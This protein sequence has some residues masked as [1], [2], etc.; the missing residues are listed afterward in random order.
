MK[1]NSELR[2]GIE[3]NL[4]RYTLII[5]CIVVVV[6]SVIGDSII[7]A[8]LATRDRQAFRSNKV[9]SVVIRHLAAVDIFSAI[10]NTLPRI[11]ALV[12]DTWVVGEFLGHFEIHTSRI[13]YTITALL[14]CEMAIVK[15]VC[16]RHPLRAFYWSKRFGRRICALLWV[17]SLIINAPLMIGSLIMIGDT[18]YFEYLMYSCYYNFDSPKSPNWLKMYY[19]ICHGILTIFPIL[20]LFITSGLILAVA[21]RTASRY[22][23]TIRREGVLTVLLT[24]AAFLI[25]LLP[26]F[27]VSVL[28]SAGIMNKTIYRATNFLVYLNTMANFFIYLLSVS[29]FRHYLK[30]KVLHLLAFVKR[31]MMNDRVERPSARIRN[32]VSTFTIS[33]GANAEEQM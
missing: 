7:L 18:Q 24:V 27:I 26:F 32:P 28:E 23:Q 11:P 29:S 5:W 25:S 19:V 14:T 31:P 13:C 2:Y 15:L 22:R 20:I 6:T 4:E 8:A 9:I 21:K 10:S 30:V 1:T 16:L 12:T 17:L 3:D 33:T